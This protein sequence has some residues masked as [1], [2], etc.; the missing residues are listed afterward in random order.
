MYCSF[1]FRTVVCGYAKMKLPLGKLI[2]TQG[3]T[4]ISSSLSS[5]FIVD[6]NFSMLNVE[7]RREIKVSIISFSPKKTLN[8]FQL[9][10]LLLYILFVCS[11]PNNNKIIRKKKFELMMVNCCGHFV[12]WWH[13]QLISVQ[14]IPLLI[15]FQ[16]KC[17][18]F[19]LISILRVCEEWKKERNHPMLSR[20]FFHLLFVLL[21]RGK[22]SN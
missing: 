17:I 18:F 16:M 8:N 7:E 14:L 10:S 19:E 6:D 9:I 20:H 11:V 13:C 21:E 12:L 4:S 1:P 2:I 15:F 3:F 5:S 22:Q